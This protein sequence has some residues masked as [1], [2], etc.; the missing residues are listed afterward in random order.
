MEEVNSLRFYPNVILNLFLQLVNARLYSP[1][2]NLRV[3][4]SEPMFPLISA[5]VSLEMELL[6]ERSLLA[7][8]MALSTEVHIAVTIK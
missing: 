8:G 2:L 6:S 7:S 1:V 5:T 4:S 3:L